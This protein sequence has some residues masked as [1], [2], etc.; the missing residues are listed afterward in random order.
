[1]FYEESY[2]NKV[3]QFQE[4]V[5]DEKH[6]GENQNQFSDSLDIDLDLS[7]LF[8]YLENTSDWACVH[9]TPHQ[10]SR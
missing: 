10:S 9:L 5:R 7:H 4:K 6:I 1:L 2:L 8:F 3:K